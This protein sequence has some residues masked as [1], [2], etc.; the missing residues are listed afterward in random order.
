MK[1]IFIYKS[2]SLLVNVSFAIKKTNETN[3]FLANER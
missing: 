3:D 1:G 2:R